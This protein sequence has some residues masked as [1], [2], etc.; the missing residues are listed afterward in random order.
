MTQVLKEDSPVQ[1]AGFSVSHAYDAH[2]E[3]GLRAAFEYRDLGVR[4]ATGGRVDAHVIRALPGQ[5]LTPQLHHHET[6]F[7]IVY[8]LRGWITFR[9]EGVGEVRFSAGSCVHQPA[10]L[11]HI[12]VAHS[13]DLEM[14]EIVAPAAFRTI[15]D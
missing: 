12:E 9:Y 14:L 8:V 6:E 13:D 3:R 7:Q 2:F 5:H 4:D 10:G 11:R 1:P 15:N